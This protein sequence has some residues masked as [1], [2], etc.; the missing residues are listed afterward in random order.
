M[1]DRNDSWAIADELCGSTGYVL[2]LMLSHC[3]S[4]NLPN[5]I[6]KDS[7]GNM[8]S[9]YASIPDD[10]TENVQADLI[11]GVVLIPS[12]GIFSFVCKWDAK[13]KNMI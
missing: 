8:D 9:D 1:D 5:C 4:E 11:E 7:E 3:I 6:D 13:D 10:Q 2:T 12:N